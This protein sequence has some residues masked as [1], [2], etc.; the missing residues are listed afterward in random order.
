MNK[1]EARNLIKERRMNLSMEYID[2]A[3]DKIFEKLLE[4]EDFKNAK[5]IMSYMDFKNEVKTDKINDYIK[6]AGKTLVLPKVITKEKMIAIEDEDKYIISPFGN[7]E[8]DGEEYI[9]EI[10]LIITP[11]VAFDRDKNRVG[12]GRGY[13]DRFFVKHPNAK[14][15]AIAFEKQIIDEGIETDKYDKK[16]D[17]LITE[18]NIIK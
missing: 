3:S 11:G 14:K 15:I 17:I 8:P 2:T 4:N 10:D 5:V 7:S 6:K 1:K 18:N 12:F 9:G 16:V 13:Y